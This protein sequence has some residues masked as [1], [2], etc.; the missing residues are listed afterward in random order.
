MSNG[1]GMVSLLSC[2][3]SDRF[4]AFG[5]VAG[6]MYYP[7]GG[8]TPPQPTPLINIHGDSDSSVPYGGSAV[9]KLPDIASW[10]ADRAKDNG[11]NPQPTTTNIDAVTTLTSW[12]GCRNNAS[13]QNIRLRGGGHLWWP[14]ATQTLWQFMSKHSL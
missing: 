2:K 3:L 13:V 11:C 1:G 10:S 8:C 6:A 4:A 14:E 7:A 5:I 12:S 9:R